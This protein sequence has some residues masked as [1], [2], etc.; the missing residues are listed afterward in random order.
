VVEV[1]SKFGLAQW[2]FNSMCTEATVYVCL[3]FSFL[4]NI[5]NVFINKTEVGHRNM[6]LNH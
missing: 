5:L 1:Y 3:N 4:Y 2:S 6:L